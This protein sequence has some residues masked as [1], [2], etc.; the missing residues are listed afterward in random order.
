MPSP[1][2]D[3][4]RSGWP[5]SRSGSRRPASSC[6]RAPSSLAKARLTRSSRPS[7]SEMKTIS[8]SESKVASHSALEC[9]S[10]SRAER[11]RW[12]AHSR[13]AWRWPAMMATVATSPASQAQRATICWLMRSGSKSTEKASPATSAATAQ[14]G[15]HGHLAGPGQHH[16]RPHHAHQHAVADGA[17]DLAVEQGHRHRDQHHQ[18]RLEAGEAQQGGHPARPLEHPGVEAVG[19]QQDGADE[20][21]RPGGAPPGEQVVGEV[22]GHEDRDDQPAQPEQPLEPLGHLALGDL[23][24]ADGDRA[25]HR[26][27]HSFSAPDGADPGRGAGS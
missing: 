15:D 25:V 8:P 21:R 16:R 7:R 1:G 23:V 11:S 5:A 24:G 10:P 2:T 6:G 14:S 17:V 19:R 4:Q 3:H 27:G 26:D 9:S 20:E 18:R 13:A 12:A 22:H